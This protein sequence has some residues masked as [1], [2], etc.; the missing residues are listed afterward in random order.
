[1]ARQY[2]YHVVRKM[3][4]PIALRCAAAIV[5]HY[6]KI[7]LVAV[8]Q[9]VVLHAHIILK[10]AYALVAPM[11]A[12]LPAKTLVKQVVKKHVLILVKE[13]HLVSRQQVQSM[14]MNTWI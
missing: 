7:P 13:L 4:A 14:D 1:M 5:L 8:V 9:T 6:V 11:T 10:V 2:L 12:H 3:V